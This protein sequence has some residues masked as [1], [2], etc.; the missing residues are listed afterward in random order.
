MPLL[1]KRNWKFWASLQ[2]PWQISLFIRH[3]AYTFRDC[4]RI[5]RRSF[6]KMPDLRDEVAKFDLFSLRKPKVFAL[7][8]LRRYLTKDGP[9][10][11]NF[12]LFNMDKRTLRS[13]IWK[14]RTFENSW[15]FANYIETVVIYFCYILTLSFHIVISFLLFTSTKSMK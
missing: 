4:P 6:W 8:I 13:K 5:N 15:D 10:F 1:W 3:T 9:G 12:L 2:T 11:E 7:Q 14:A